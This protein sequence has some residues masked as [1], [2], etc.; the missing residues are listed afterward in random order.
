[1]FVKIKSKVLAF[2]RVRNYTSCSTR[3]SCMASNH[4]VAL[5]H[6]SLSGKSISGISKSLSSKLFFPATLTLSAI[7]EM[8][9]CG[10]LGGYKE[11][12]L[13]VCHQLKTYISTARLLQ[14][15]VLKLVV[16]LLH[17]VVA[18]RLE[19]R[20]RKVSFLKLPYLW[21][22]SRYQSAGFF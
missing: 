15:W 10:L 13:L 6:V 16:P 20:R 2:I 4:S 19:R 22:Q 9:F 7:S 1:M 21:S 18:N 12:T 17:T 8:D 3:L 11:S 14:C 5:L